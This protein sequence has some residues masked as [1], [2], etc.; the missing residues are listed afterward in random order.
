MPRS[1]GTGSVGAS[2]R[3]RIRAAAARDRC[4]WIAAAGSSDVA[5][6]AARGVRTTTASSTGARSPAP[7]AGMPVT[8]AHEHGDADGELAEPRGDRGRTGTRVGRRGEPAVGL[9]QGGELVRPRARRPAA[10]RCRRAGPSAVAVMSARL[11]SARPSVA[12]AA[13]AA[14]RGAATPAST[15]QPASAS[16]AGGQNAHIASDGARTEQ[17]RDPGRQ[18]AADDDVAHRRRRPHRRAPAGHRAAAAAGSSG[19]ATASRWYSVVRSSVMPRRATSWDTRR[20]RYRSTPRPMPNAR[21]ATVRHRQLEDGRHLRGARDQ[22]GGHGG[23]RDRRSPSAR[24]CARSEQ[25]ERDGAVGRDRRVAELP[26]DGALAGRRRARQLRQRTSSALVRGARRSHDDDVVRERDERVPVRDEQHGPAGVPQRPHGVE[27]HLLAGRVEVRRRLVEHDERRV[28]E[29]GAR[30]RDA[31]P[32]AEAEALAT[33]PERR[34]PAVGQ[35]RDHGVEPGEPRGPLSSSP[36]PRRRRS[37]RARWSRRSSTG[38]WGS[39]ATCAHQTW[40]E[41]DVRQVECPSTDGAAGVGHGAR[42]EQRRSHARSSCRRRSARQRDDPAGR[43]PPG[44]GRAARQSRPGARTPTP[45]SR[46]RAR[47][48]SGAVRVPA[49]GAAV[50][51]TANASSAA[52]T[53]S[54]DAWNCTP[55]CRSGR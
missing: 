7:T 18:Q 48:R 23:Q 8:S 30:Q 14:I 4:T 52:A 12:R 25:R 29:Q 51:S 32:L 55:T 10:D 39:H 44:R 53:P 31:L 40:R 41:V 42:A 3:A 34:R 26:P 36:R 9:P 49:A 35:G 16:P 46:S 37:E 6:N 2:S 43:A 38:R 45:S 11:C 20:S 50:S 1:V 13:R 22:P 17:R 21:T 47:R 54:A 27:H 19:R 33:A 28:G 5:S 15:R 24:A